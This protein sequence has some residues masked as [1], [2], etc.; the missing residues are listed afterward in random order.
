MLLLRSVSN[1]GGEMP[2][3]CYGIP[4]TGSKWRLADWILSYLPDAPINAPHY[5]ERGRESI[6]R[7]VS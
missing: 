1:G 2:R 7:L 5:G 4:Y 6:R 3:Q